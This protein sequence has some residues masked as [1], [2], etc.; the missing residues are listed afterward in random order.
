[1]R[2]RSGVSTYLQTFVLIAVALGGSLIAYR[3]LSGYATGVAGPGLLVSNVSVRQ[4]ASA[5]VEV[6]T[7]TNTGQSSF[8]SETILNP[9]ISATLGYCYSAYNPS[10][11]VLI[12]GTCPTMATDP[13]RLQPGVTI[14][15]GSSV[16]FELTI[17]A[18]N[19]FTVGAEYPVGVVAGS[20]IQQMVQ[21]VVDPA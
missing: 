10:T 2:R 18:P 6:M 21:T 1:M 17:A 19:A 4:G 5:A 15:P 3:S 11:R 13:T 7:V 14:P 16:V 12:T 9:T 8:S 20:G